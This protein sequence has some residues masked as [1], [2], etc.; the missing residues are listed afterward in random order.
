M[1]FV[2]YDYKKEKN[3]G[4]EEYVFSGDIDDDNG[5]EGE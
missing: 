2:G 1:S 3:T 4:M 5:S